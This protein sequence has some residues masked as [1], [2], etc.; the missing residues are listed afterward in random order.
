VRTGENISERL[1]QTEFAFLMTDIAL[2]MTMMHIASH[3]DVDSKKKMRNQKNA[4]RAYDAVSNLSGKVKL[5]E[6]ERL[7]LDEKLTELKS[8]LQELGETF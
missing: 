3:A 2:A 8:A 6:D 1:Q 5:T 4:R 7:E